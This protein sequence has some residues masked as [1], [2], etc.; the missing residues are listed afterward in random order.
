MSNDPNTSSFFTH[1]MKIYG[2]CAACEF[3]TSGDTIDQLDDKFRH[4]FI[5]RG[6]ESYFYKEKN[7]EKIRKIS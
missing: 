5:M 2:T 3:E 7:I 1:I 6:H 4:H